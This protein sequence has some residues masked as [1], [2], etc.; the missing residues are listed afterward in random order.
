MGTKALKTMCG[1]A[2]YKEVFKSSGFQGRREK[3]REGSKNELLELIL[4]VSKSQIITVL[5]GKHKEFRLLN[6]VINF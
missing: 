4:R 5:V 6:I 1:S 3:K 2:F